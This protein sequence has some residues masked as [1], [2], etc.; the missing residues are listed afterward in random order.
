MSTIDS[1][2]LIDLFG[3]PRLRSTFLPDSPQAHPCGLGRD[4]HV[5]HGPKERYYTPSVL[6]VIL[7]LWFLKEVLRSGRSWGVGIDYQDRT[8]QEPSPSATWM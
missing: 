4:I 2:T 3:D 6:C 8:R 5:A 1:W 7:V